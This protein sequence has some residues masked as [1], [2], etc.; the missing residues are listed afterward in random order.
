MRFKKVWDPDGVFYHYEITAKGVD[1][2][3][4]GLEKTIEKWEQYERE[5]RKKIWQEDDDYKRDYL[6]QKHNDV[7]NILERLRNQQWRGL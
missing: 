4:K 1:I 7:V 3:N 5:L 6:I 2:M